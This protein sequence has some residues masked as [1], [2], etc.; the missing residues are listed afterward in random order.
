MKKLLYI[1]I[2]STLLYS[3]KHELESP[4]WETEMI[5]PIAHTK[6]NISNMITEVDSSNISSN[7]DSDSLVSLIFSQEIMDMNFDTLVKIDAI[8]DEQTHTLDSA[9]FADV[10]IADTATIGESINEIPLGTLLLP[11]GST[12]SIPAIP[13]IANEDTINI[14]ASEYFETMTLHEGTLTVELNNGY[15]TD[16]S[17]ISLSLINA[18]NQSTIATFSFPVVPSGSIVSESVS[19]AGQTIDDNIFAILHNMDINASN[20]RLR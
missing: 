7:I 9:S 3:C 6:M 8:T 5:V 11:N 4:T 1:I 15:P 19:I 13:N 17:N 10:V 18:T 14:D 12:N 2:C 20:G 16:I